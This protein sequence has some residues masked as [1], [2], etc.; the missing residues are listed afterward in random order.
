MSIKRYEAPDIQE[1]LRLVKRDLGPEAVILSVNKMNHVGDGLFKGTKR[2][3]VVAMADDQK[4]NPVGA[5]LSDGV[6]GLTLVNRLKE[7]VQDIKDMFLAFL[8]PDNFWQSRNGHGALLKL[9]RGLA[10]CG[11][12]RM[13]L[14]RFLAKSGLRADIEKN[15][16]KNLIP[17]II[18]RLQNAFDVVDLSATQK[19]QKVWVFI[20]PTGVG[21]TTTIAKLGAKFSL[22]HKKVVLVTLDTYRIGAIEQLKT[23]AEIIGVPFHAVSKVQ[24]LTDLLENHRDRDCILIDTAGRSPSNSFHLNELRD[25]LT[26][27]P[28]VD[29]H[30][31]LSATTK[32]G[33][34]VSA[35]DQFST[36][37]LRSLIFTKIDETEDYGP[38]FDQLV[39]FSIPVSYLGVGQKVPQDIE[40]ASKVKIANLVLNPLLHAMKGRP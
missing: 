30:L 12:D 27:H 36:L 39:R 29:T 24:L 2:V 38:M 17:M 25:F 8:G 15:G 35:I 14:S 34:L 3:E 28:T 33:D 6:D 21:K 22:E 4:N 13:W 31:V 32:Y 20:G 18:S 10:A 5:K 7:D 19:G 23:Y 26:K 11:I 40:V 16:K 9:Y 1:A 37:S